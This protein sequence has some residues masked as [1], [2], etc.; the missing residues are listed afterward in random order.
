[1]VEAVVEGAAYPWHAVEEEAEEAL[2]EE[3][4]GVQVGAGVDGPSYWH[5]PCSRV[6]SHL[7]PSLRAA[8]YAFRR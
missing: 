7:D 4:L 2:H 5:W 3:A 8:L 1:M 6:V